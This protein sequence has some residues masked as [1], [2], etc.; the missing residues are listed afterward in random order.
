MN[1]TLA[2][3]FFVVISRLDFTPST[4]ASRVRLNAANVFLKTSSLDP[5]LPKTPILV[6]PGIGPRQ[7]KVADGHPQ[8]TVTT[9]TPSSRDVLTRQ[10]LS[11]SP[12]MFRTGSTMCTP[13]FSQLLG[14][15]ACTC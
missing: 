2:N 15:V 4:N 6:S 3:S 10:S 12:R 11:Y 13:Y 5:R 7:V 14:D 1:I 8:S 9:V